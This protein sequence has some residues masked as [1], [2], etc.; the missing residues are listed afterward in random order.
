MKKRV[1]LMMTLML[2]VLSIFSFG[3]KS[4]VKATGLTDED[5]I[6]IELN[7]IFVPNEVIFDFP[8]VT[9]SAYNSSITWNSDNEDIIKEKIK[10]NWR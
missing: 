4:N 8:L 9:E 2:V 1:S 3:L 5:I 10:D 7:N 6:N